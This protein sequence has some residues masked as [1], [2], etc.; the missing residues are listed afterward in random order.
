MFANAMG[1]VEMIGRHT[2]THTHLATDLQELPPEPSWPPCL[3]LYG[4]VPPLEIFPAQL[5]EASLAFLISW[6]TAYVKILAARRLQ[7]QQ[8]P[9]LFIGRTHSNRLH[10]YLHHQLVRPLPPPTE[11]AV[12]TL[13]KPTRKSWPWELNF[14]TD[15]LGWLRALR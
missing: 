14:I 15:L 6:H 8:Q 9:A 2:H 5:K 4:L 11:Q 1:L 12:L 13:A 10:A 7:D 3:K